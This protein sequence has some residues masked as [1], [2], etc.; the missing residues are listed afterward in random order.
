M[1]VKNLNEVD[2]RRWNTL[3]KVIWS[4]PE[5]K[6]DPLYREKESYSSSFENALEMVAKR[7]HLNP[8]RL[9]L[10]DPYFADGVIETLAGKK[11]FYYDAEYSRVETLFRPNG[12]FKYWD[13]D[14]PVEKI[15]FFSEYSPSVYVRGN[16]E[17][18]L[19]LRGGAIKEAFE[20][21]KIDT[22]ERRHGVEKKIVAPRDFILVHT[23]SALARN[24]LKVVELKNWLKAVKQLFALDIYLVA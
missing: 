2:P 12:K 1:G 11:M 5:L 13:I 16:L 21:G 6:E 7:N 15:R 14:V 18:V 8:R 22:R 4:H 17:R 3:S 10:E 23:R 20:V 9:N 24:H 19:V